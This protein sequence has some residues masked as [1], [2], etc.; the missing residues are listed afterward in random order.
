MFQE[1]HPPKKNGL[2]KVAKEVVQP[3]A[4]VQKVTNSSYCQ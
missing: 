4:E 3:L 2:E 1:V